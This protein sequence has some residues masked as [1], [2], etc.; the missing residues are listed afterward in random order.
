MKTARW[1]ASNFY[2]GDLYM[3]Q[4]S[5]LIIASIVFLGMK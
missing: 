5:V 3:V 4:C 2:I 1:N